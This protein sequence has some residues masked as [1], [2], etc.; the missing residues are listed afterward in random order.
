MPLTALLTTA[1]AA[2]FTGPLSQTGLRQDE[3]RDAFR[4]MLVGDSMVMRQTRA[5][6]RR[7]APTTE[8]ILLTGPTGAGK[9][10]AARA[11]HAVSSYSRG[12]MVALNCAAIPADLIE[13]EL[14]GHAKGAFTGATA[15]RV[16]RFEQAQNGTLF[17][18]EIGDM[19]ASAQL[20]LLRVLEE[21]RFEPVGSSSS[22]VFSG[23]LLCATHR[24]LATEVAAGRFRQDLYYRITVLPIALPALVQRRQ[25]IPALIAHLATQAEAA[26]RFDAAA[27][28]LLQQHDWPGNV[29]EL[30]NLVA[31]ACV[32]LPGQEIRA[33][34]LAALMSLGQTVTVLAN[35][36]PP[37]PPTGIRSE[38]ADMERQRLTTAL[39]NAGGN[40]AKAARELSL[41]RTTLVEKMRRMRLTH[42]RKGEE[43]MAP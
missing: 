39:E 17:L 40:V 22:A 18:D 28:A 38:L 9:E 8:T 36:A 4:Q 24:D 13:S 5:L 11:I 6:L 33:P 7:V 20:R 42:A 3:P 27:A 29:R 43:E 2:P 37:T 19:P 32:L 26:P 25:D 23:R 15:R 35:T 31:R 14:F 1:T 12:P 30:R 21:R 34:V 41:N 16:G 10:V